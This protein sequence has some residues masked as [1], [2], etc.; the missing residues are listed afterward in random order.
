LRIEAVGLPG[1]GWR[2]AFLSAAGYDALAMTP[3]SALLLMALLV[4]ALSACLRL[5]APGD[6]YA[7]CLTPWGGA[8]YSPSTA[9][10]VRV[11]TRFEG[12][13]LRIELKPQRARPVSLRAAEGAGR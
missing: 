7:Y 1:Q 5:R 3:R 11:V 4:A 2:V 6:T 13:V 12:G 8:R 10:R 9:E